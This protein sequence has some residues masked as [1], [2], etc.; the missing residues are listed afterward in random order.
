MDSSSS[1]GDG[2]LTVSML[3]DVVES[4]AVFSGGTEADSLRERLDMIVVA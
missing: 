4:G 1:V 2:V 3:L